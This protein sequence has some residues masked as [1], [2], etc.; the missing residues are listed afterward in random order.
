[1]V[2]GPRNIFLQGIGYLKNLF[3]SVCFFGY[4]AIAFGGK[5]DYEV[6]TYK[7][8]EIGVIGNTYS[9]SAHPNGMIYF[10]NSE[11]LLEFDGIHWRNIAPPE[12]KQVISV[13]V[14]KDQRIYIGGKKEFGFLEVSSD[15]QYKYTSLRSM[16]DSVLKTDEIW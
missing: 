13:L 11:G 2:H 5:D 1:M 6:I 8:S 14:G 12:I 16:L 10:A 15:F 3:L 4:S 9:G 7:P